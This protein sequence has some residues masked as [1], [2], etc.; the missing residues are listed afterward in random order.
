MRES[1]AIVA[2][3]GLE[4]MWIRHEAVHK[5]LW[6][7]LS[8]MGLEP[9]VQD[10]ADRLVTVNTIKV[11][12]LLGPRLLHASQLLEGKELACC[13]AKNPLLNLA[14]APLQ[15]PEGV[16]WAA[17]CANAMAKFN[18]E[19]AGG[20]GPTVGKVRRGGLQRYCLIKASCGL[21]LPVWCAACALALRLLDMNC[22]LTCHLVQVWRVGLMGYNATPAMVRRCVSARFCWLAINPV[23]LLRCSGKLDMFIIGARRWSW[24]WR[25]SRTAWRSRAS[26]P[27]R[28]EGRPG[29]WLP[30]TVPVAAALRAS[31]RLT[32]DFVP[33]AGGKRHFV[34]FYAARGHQS[35][36]ALPRQ[37][38]L[39]DCSLGTRFVN[40]HSCS[41]LPH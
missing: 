26:S 11:R 1:L 37:R 5:Q 16:D 19:I 27:R 13:G 9:F 38:M 32:A 15:V 17:V 12:G 10:P 14:F 3:E 22:S 8:A 4:S 6:A 34:L 33:Q 41:R 25:R 2:E 29:C 36:A 24:C 40:C 20:L 39:L 21:G 7:G 23:F 28:S 35:V 30:C 31:C 18:V